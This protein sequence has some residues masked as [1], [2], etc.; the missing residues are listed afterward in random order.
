MSGTSI[1]PG[2]ILLITLP[3][4]LP[5]GHEQEGLRPAIVVGIPQG[6]VRYPV[7]IV[8]PLTTSGGIWVNKNPRLYHFL[9]PQAG[10]QKPS[11]ALIDQIRAV[12]ANR[13][14]DHLGSL[15][16]DVLQQIRMNLIDLLY[17]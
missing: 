1:K 4:H 6:P 15:N 13:I 12:D 17:E 10:L 5:K 7:I 14:K 16:M 11:I 9:P 3:S 2:D 8:V